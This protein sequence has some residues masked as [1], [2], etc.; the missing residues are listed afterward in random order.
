MCRVLHHPSWA[1][2][3]NT[4]Y[5]KIKT[6]VCARQGSFAGCC[7][8][9]A[10]VLTYIATPLATQ[11]HEER[12]QREQDLLVAQSASKLVSQRPGRTQTRN[13]RHAMALIRFRVV[14]QP[15]CGE[16]RPVSNRHNIPQHVKQTQ[17][18][19]LVSA[20]PNTACEP[21][22]SM[23]AYLSIYLSIY[24]S[25]TRSPGPSLTNSTQ[26]APESTLK[27]RVVWM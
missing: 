11:G 8:T 5:N 23:S 18:A 15:V 12:E 27:S 21:K 24:L 10:M 2:T 3:V 7:Y 6:I 25:P 16:A 22:D 20:T 19:A 4:H 13:S 1:N 14:A 26:C 17:H 9:P